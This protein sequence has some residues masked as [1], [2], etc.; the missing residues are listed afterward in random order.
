MQTYKKIPQRV[1]NYVFL[2]AIYNKYK[3]F[4]EKCQACPFLRFFDYLC[5]LKRK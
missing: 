2:T 4:K 3:D 1:V 5:K